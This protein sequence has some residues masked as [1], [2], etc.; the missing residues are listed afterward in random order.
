MQ[1]GKE[2]ARQLRLIGK[3]AF[4]FSLNRVIKTKDLKQGSVY[5][6]WDGKGTGVYFGKM[7]CNVEISLEREPGRDLIDLPVQI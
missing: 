4:C 1:P 6:R 3:G 7:E 5:V 2:D